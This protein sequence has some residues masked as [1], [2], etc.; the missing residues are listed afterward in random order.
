[1]AHAFYINSSLS[2]NMMD[3]LVGGYSEEKRKLR[4]A[5]SIAMNYNEYIDIFS[6][7]R[8]IMAQ[9]PIPP[10]I[11]GY[12]AGEE[13][14]N[15]YVDEWDPKRKKH[16]RKP[17]EVA[18]KL[19][20]EAGYPGGIG[21]DGNQLTIYYDHSGAGS[22]SF[23]A[24]FTWMRAQ[25][26]RIGVR[27]E[28]RGSD[29][30]RFREKRAEGNWQMSSSGWLADY[31]DPENFLFLFYGPNSLVKVGGANT[32]NYES[33]EYDRLFTQMES[34]K[35]SPERM[36]IIKQLMDTIQK[37]A[38]AVWMTHPVDYG[39]YHEWYKN[40]KP[41]K[42][43]AN[44]KKFVRVEPELRVAAQ[45]AWNKPITWPIYLI[46]ALL[47]AGAIPAAVQIHRQE[48]GK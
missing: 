40:T 18:R 23:R 2:F 17:I 28:E 36:E 21:P 47:L 46:V 8:G 32:V 48:K 31:P 33:A 25:V 20:A 4:Q 7:G 38:P 22:T 30:S 16:V 12:R 19:L 27:F 24:T 29:L 10:G 6:N 13:G 34:M 1:V 42:M 3:D 35:N 44:T 37:D 43:S 45:A 11:F 9:G 5:V 39:L 15:P 14:T 26:S 41:H